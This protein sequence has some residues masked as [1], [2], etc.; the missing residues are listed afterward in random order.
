MFFSRDMISVS[1]Q[2][3]SVDHKMDWFKCLFCLDLI[4]DGDLVCV[5]SCD[6]WI[7]EW[8]VD[9]MK[10][11]DDR[12]CKICSRNIVVF[13]VYKEFDLAR[14]TQTVGV[15]MMIQ[16]LDEVILLMSESCVRKLFS[17]A[18]Y[19]VFQKVTR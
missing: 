7:H 4:K 3:F 16:K 2:Q 9:T 1:D 11:M 18:N 15:P 5:A 14:A 8:C 6:H 12:R 17:E 13:S 10:S 19:L